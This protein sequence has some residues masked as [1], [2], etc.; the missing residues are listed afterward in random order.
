MHEVANPAKPADEGRDGEAVDGREGRILSCCANRGVAVSQMTH[1]DAT[2]MKVSE[3]SKHRED[4]EDETET[5]ADELEGVLTTWCSVGRTLKNLASS[6][7]VV[8]VR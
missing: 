7:R 1:V 2:D 8:L 3:A 4:A 6:R 5:K